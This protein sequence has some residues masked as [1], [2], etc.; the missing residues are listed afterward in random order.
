[1]RNDPSGSGFEHEA[2]EAGPREMQQREQQE[3]MEQQ[4][5]LARHSIDTRSN[6]GMTVSPVASHSNTAGL[7]HTPS[8]SAFAVPVSGLGNGNEHGR[9]NRQ[10]RE[11][12]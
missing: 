9:E 1:M 11:S 10:S 7:A 2:R 6:V 5:R 3:A 4:R 8:A 12:T